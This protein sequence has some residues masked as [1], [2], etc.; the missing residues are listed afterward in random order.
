[1]HRFLVQSNVLR[2]GE[3]R[4]DG[5]VAQ[6]IRRVLRMREG[7]EVRLFSGGK[8]EYRV[9]LS[10][11]GKDTVF[12]KVIERVELM[13]EPQVELSLYLALLNKAEKFEFALQKC[14]E[15]GVSRFVPVAAERSVSG[16]GGG[17]ASKRDRWQRIIQE[18]VEQS[19]RGTLPLLE[20]AVSLKDALAEE[21]RRIERSASDAP[22][23]SLITAPTS[24]MSL[25]RA[26]IGRDGPKGSIS[27]FVGP[28]GGFSAAE[29][30][31]A[32]EAGV[33]PVTVGPRV[34]RAET[35]A[36]AICGMILYALGEAGD[37]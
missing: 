32:V 15:L 10:S 4:L 7:D 22:Y 13:S 36:V 30:D 27:L 8:Y 29:L 6:Q 18:A 37:I 24:E 20:E 14:T 11:L 33:L 35:A 12:G 31:A 21:A 17:G 3:V 9:R 28:E 34:L 16:S 2:S 26:L 1:M 5:E 23:I 19:G 25:R